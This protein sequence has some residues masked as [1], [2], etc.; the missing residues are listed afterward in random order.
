MAVRSEAK[1]AYLCF[2]TKLRVASLALLRSVQST[3][4][5]KRGMTLGVIS[6][7]PYRYFPAAEIDVCS[8]RR[9]I[10]APIIVSNFTIIYDFNIF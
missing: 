4:L 2:D 1:I 3:C 9:E 6:F 10:P 5:S 8:E 7:G